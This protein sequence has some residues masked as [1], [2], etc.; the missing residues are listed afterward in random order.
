MPSLPGEQPSPALHCEKRGLITATRKEVRSSQVMEGTIVPSPGQP[1]PPGFGTQPVK[2]LAR[3]RQC[4]ES[5]I[6]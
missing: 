1:L 3:F 2:A 4:C 5:K 6:R